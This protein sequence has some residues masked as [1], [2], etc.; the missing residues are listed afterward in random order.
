MLIEKNLVETV[1]ERLKMLRISS[2]M[3]QKQV[4]EK[5]NIASSTYSKYELGEHTPG[6]EMLLKLSQIY[7]IS[8]NYLA[9]DTDQEVIYI[10]NLNDKQKK[11]LF[12]MMNYF[13]TVNN[14]E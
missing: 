10:G 1:S 2:N 11:L 3:T 6:L 4:A 12:S 14:L 9:G 5:L 13:K 7:D 8:I